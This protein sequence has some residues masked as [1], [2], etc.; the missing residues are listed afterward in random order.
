M[1]N[2]TTLMQGPGGELPQTLEGTFQTLDRKATHVDLRPGQ[3]EVLR[4]LDSLLGHKDVVMRVSTGGGKTIVALTFLYHIMKKEG[5]PSV[6]LVPTTQLV[7]QVL[8]E[9]ANIG[10]L[11]HGYPAGETL[12]HHECLQ[13]EA[14]IVCTYDKMFNGRS[15]FNRSDIGFEPGAIVLDDV[16]AG[17]EVIRSCYNA[18][19]D[20]DAFRKL[21]ELLSTSMRAQAPGIWKGITDGDEI[22]VI[23]I[24]FWIWQDQLDAIRN[25]LS[26]HASEGEL[27]FKWKHLADR[28]E[29]ARCTFSGYS[30]EVRLDPPPVNQWR[31][32]LVAK[33]RLFMSASVN[34]GS[35]LIREIGC[36]PSALDRQVI[37]SS[38]RGPGERMIITTSL[39]DPSFEDSAVASMARELAATTNVVV[40]V[41]SE[42][43]SKIWVAAGARFVGGNEVNSAI[44]VLRASSQGNFVVMAQ[45]YDGIDLPDDACR[46]LIIHGVPQGGSLAD[47]ADQAMR[48]NVAG[49][50]NRIVNRLEQGL[51]RAV[52]SPVDFCAVLLVGR[53]LGAFI[54]LRQTLSHLSPATARQLDMSRE[55]SKMAGSETDH[56]ASIKSTVMQCLRRDPAWRAYY[57]QQ[58][59]SVV[60]GQNSVE[61]DLKSASLAERAA[62]DRALA[63]DYIGA[64]REIERVTGDGMLGQEDVAAL[65]ETL[66]GY[67]YHVDK[68]TAHEIQ[69]KAYMKS[70]GVSRPVGIV[71]AKH[72]KVTSQSELISAK[73][74]SYS[75]VNAALSDLETLRSQL[76]Y[77]NPYKSVEAALRELGAWLGAA[78]SRPENEG[79][80]GPDVLWR[81]HDRMIVIEAKSENKTRLH[82]DDAGQLMLS[83][84]WAEE[85][86]PTIKPIHLVIA[87]N[88]TRADNLNDFS[89]GA[90]V[91]TESAILELVGRVKNLAIS[92]INEGALFTTNASSIQGHIVRHKILSQDIVNLGVRIQ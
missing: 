31:P 59:G 30:C 35:S 91:L 78:A 48:P 55:L 18:R 50:R 40:L 29:L 46:V 72:A 23:D 3:L 9:A 64:A 24:P 21:R 83:G 5:R 22:A 4:T 54:G 66:A 86:F 75:Y 51:G 17:L 11:A 26:E 14:L 63:R 41:S 73:L 38:D 7:D 90:V 77:S 2:F 27:L 70:A 6:Y 61:G 32:Y 44:S 84:N 80:R 47:R 62:M 34:D 58:I 87:S 33:H 85:H 43:Q 39:V 10:I 52:R 92:A 19:V 28:L 74:A 60:S 71:T 37:A 81:F 79:N 57:Q 56:L 1:V 53:E 36:D 76:A 68:P 16:H 82:K 69:Q 42:A 89:F 45:R 25:I 13:A 15:T 8:R 20:G 88:T 49:T 12:P 67:Y 65:M